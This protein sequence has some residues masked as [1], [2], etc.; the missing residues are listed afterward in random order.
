L[1]RLRDEGYDV[2]IRS[3]YLLLKDVPYVNGQREVKRGIL[4]SE[5]STAGER[6]AEP[7]THVAM[8]AG[9]YPCDSDGKP[10]EKIRHQSERKELFPGFFVGHSFSSKPVYT[11]KYSDYYH[12][13]TTYAVILQ[14]PAEALRPGVTA[15]TYPVITTMEAE[16]VFRYLDTATSRSG[17]GVAN[18]KL[19]LSRIAI[20]GL[21]GTG[22]YVFDLIAKTPVREIH[23]FDGDYFLSHNAFRS[24]G[25][26]SVEELQAKPRK[27]EY[28][29]QVY[30][31]MRRGVVPHPDYVGTHN[32]AELQTMDFVFLCMDANPAKPLVVGR[33]EEWGIRFIDVGM[34]VHL[35]GDSLL[36]LL[37]TTTSTPEHRESIHKRAPLR[38]ATPDA[39][40]EQN[41]QIADLNALNAALS[42]IKW[43]KLCGFYLDQVREHNTT[44][45]ISD[46]VLISDDQV[47]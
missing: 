17:I 46:N 32:V 39:D 31:K 2:E 16:S 44:Y 40:Y 36:G 41:I 25:A 3:S 23:L 5:L 15:Q 34:G 14:G 11:G 21:G 27:V 47:G 38:T 43:K 7:G 6:T 20:V 42:V 37:R 29:A 9:E 10:L 33:L 28:L 12:K 30:S 24:P 45:S 8:L 4:V 26:A 1:K 13:M 35:V 18:A 22:A 19:E